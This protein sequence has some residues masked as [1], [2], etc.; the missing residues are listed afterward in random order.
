M[1]LPSIFGHIPKAPI[2]AFSDSELSLK[3]SSITFV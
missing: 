2:S 1:L 3:C